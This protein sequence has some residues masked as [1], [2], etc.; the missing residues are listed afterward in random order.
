MHLFSKLIKPILVI[1]SVLLLVS[2]GSYAPRP[3]SSIA[4]SGIVQ[5]DVN[6]QN[7]ISNGSNISTTPVFTINF[8]QTMNSNSPGTKVTLVQNNGSVNTTSNSIELA[9]FKWSS[10][11]SVLSFAVANLPL[12]SSSKFTL[13]L[14]TA[15]TNSAGHRVFS[16]P[17]VVQ[18]T[19]GNNA[20]PTV[21]MTIPGNNSKN[22]TINPQ[23]DLVFSLPV[24]NVTTSTLILKDSSG[25]QVGLL[26][27]IT[28]TNDQDFTTRPVKSLKHN[29]LYSL[30]VE[31]QITAK[32][33]PNDHI[34]ATTFYFTTV[35]SNVPPVGD[36]MVSVN[37]K[38]LFNA[39]N[40][41]TNPL[42]SVAFNQTIDPDTIN[43]N[44]I[45]L[46]QTSLD[47]KASTTV[48]LKNFTWN[49]DN[50]TVT[51]NV[52]N[53]PLSSQESF[54]L[55]LNT[56][57]KNSQNQAILTSP[58]DVKFTSGNNSSPTVSLIKPSPNYNVST[59]PE[60]YVRFS[61]PVTG[62]NKN[63]VFLRD[64]D[65]NIIPITTPI[66]L[67]NN[68]DFSFRPIGALSYSNWYL[69]DL[70]SGIS[71]IS[72]PNNHLDKTF[73]IFATADSVTPGIAETV[74]GKDLFTNPTG[75]TTTPLFSLN[76]NESMDP[77]SANNSTITLTDTNSGT[78]IPLSNF[79]WYS[80]NSSLTF[81]T[82]ESLT[83]GSGYT[84]HIESGIK[85]ANGQA[86]LQNSLDANFTT[87]AQEF[88]AVQMTSPYPTTNVGKIPLITI[89]F[90]NPVIGV[91]A[92][93]SV[94][95]KDE[96]GN[97]VSIHLESSP[98]DEHFSF[99]PDQALLSSRVYSLNLD[100]SITDNN[101]S[102]IHLNDTQFNFATADNN[103]VLWGRLLG[104]G[105][106]SSNQT[107]GS[108]ITQS[109]SSGK[110]FMTGT[111]NATLNGQPLIGTHT[112][113]YVARYDNN[114]NL[115]SLTLAGD[116]N[117]D[118]GQPKIASDNLGNIY[119]V[120]RFGNNANS[121]IGFLDKYDESLNL[122][123][124]LTFTDLTLTDLTTDSNNNLYITGIKNT[125]V[126]PNT[127]IYTAKYSPNNSLVWNQ[128]FNS[129]SLI[130]ED[131]TPDVSIAIDKKVLYIGNRNLVFEYNSDLGRL[132]FVLTLPT[133]IGHYLY[134]KDMEAQDGYLYIL[135]Q[136][137]PNA[138]DSAEIAKYNNTE[139]PIWST[140][141]PVSSFFFSVVRPI[142]LDQYGNLYT[143][144][145]EPNNS[146]VIRK[147][148]A[149]Q[150]KP[151]WVKKIPSD[152]VPNN[153]ACLG[154]FNNKLTD[155]DLF[156]VGSTGESLFNQT[157]PGQGF[158]AFIA[159]LGAPD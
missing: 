86:I 131:T 158:S 30:S 139:Q 76:F 132:T 58:L 17:L 150:G 112:N 119:I 40:V 147:L 51:F 53:P 49:N 23:I 78:N 55:T 38:S 136:S 21:S 104:N 120:G 4:T 81:Y 22:V 36:I 107:V 7:L 152:S 118:A 124:K 92:N 6:G 63:N 135:K 44:S 27:P 126:N 79:T 14:T 97:L 144:A 89:V 82:S 67:T 33:D 50:S 65:G 95:L 29:T 88:L 20:N 16:T 71:V 122:I 11:N 66:G 28:L 54:T 18:F 148:S 35:E 123:N 13:T 129:S 24:T 115:E 145:L 56:T 42:F 128:L 154:I 133:S 101:N 96:N 39:G 25:N 109:S 91:S 61:V 34:N 3:N 127:R 59:S 5:V 87:Q 57:I 85:N 90:N 143:C 31:S 84:L 8:N 103:N 1:L 94:K 47:H 141:A 117:L 12:S 140:P 52:S 19:T 100:Q 10:N 155:G 121:T 32:K 48:P 102:N 134:I 105:S 83:A 113:Y 80:N 69:V 146:F 26:E 130:T 106:S 64:T 157:Y 116:P 60:I 9:N 156:I 73:F 108:S 138:L 110:I 43:N 159:K 72:D 137:L 75:I 15:F 111:T 149:N 125:R 45:T 93:S 46:T 77:T 74:D 114:G 70:E 153:L 62:V 99:I 41:S 98:D 37:E 2:C 142:S 68:Q 151:M